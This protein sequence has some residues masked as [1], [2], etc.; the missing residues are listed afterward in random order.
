MKYFLQKRIQM[1]MKGNLHLVLMY[2]IISLQKI[3]RVYYLSIHLLK[4]N[5]KL[6][7]IIQLKKNKNQNNID[8]IFFQTKKLNSL[9]MEMELKL[10]EEKSLKQ[11]LL[12]MWNYLL[13][14]QEIEIQNKQY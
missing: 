11:A 12:Q 8:M 13:K 14:I 7:L 3:L 10:Q 2:I 6:R 4:E 9:K 5:N 1:L